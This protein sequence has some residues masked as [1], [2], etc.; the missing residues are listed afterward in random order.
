MAIQSVKP[1]QDY[2]TVKKERIPVV[3]LRSQ[4]SENPKRE[5]IDR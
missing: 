4:I 3:P 5:P 1:L 2:G